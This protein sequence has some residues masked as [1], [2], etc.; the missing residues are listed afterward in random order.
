M[1]EC[2]C[3]ASKTVVGNSESLIH[4]RDKLNYHLSVAWNF[5]HLFSD[6]VI[7]MDLLLYWQ[8]IN[9]YVLADMHDIYKVAVYEQ[10]K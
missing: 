3:F 1:Y 4:S 7:I 10:G 9:L 8:P 2:I 6:K 5:L